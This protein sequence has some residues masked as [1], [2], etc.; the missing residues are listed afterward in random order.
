MGMISSTVIFQAIVYGLLNGSIYAL[1]SFGFTML[2]GV[3]RIVYFAY[4][5]LIVLS[6]YITVFLYTHLN[7]DPFVS[8]MV[9]A[10]LFFIIGILLYKFVIRRTIEIPHHMQMIAT[11]G[12]MIVFESLML[13]IFGGT[14]QGINIPYAASMLP[15]WR[16]VKINLPRFIGML[17]SLFLIITLFLLLKRSLFGKKFQATADNQEGAMLVGIKTNAVFMYAFAVA[18]ALEAIAGSSIIA[19]SVVDP[20]TG[21]PLIIKALLVVVVAGPG[22]I[23][24]AVV[25]GL[26][27]GI[28]EALSSVFLSASLG[29]GVLFFI[30]AFILIFKPSGFFGRVEG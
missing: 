3:M 11:L 20:Y 22:S 25:G 14:P 8:T 10:P 16:D 30:L 29:T 9:T 21:F 5:Q 23:P 2:F 24:G 26:I 12:M 13:F 6:M 7:I 28:I 15:L 1:I 18:C 17:I 19:F 4:G 27:V